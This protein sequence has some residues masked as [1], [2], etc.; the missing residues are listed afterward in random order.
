MGNKNRSKYSLL[1]GVFS[2]IIMIVIGLIIPRMY[3]INYGQ[4]VHGILTTVQQLFC[5]IALIEA[6]IGVSALQ[7]LYK[8]L[9]INDKN[10]INGILSATNIYYKKAGKLYFIILIIVSLLFPIIVKSSVPYYVILLVIFFSGIANAFSFYYYSKYLIL[11]R[12]EGK[13]YLISMIN[14]VVFILNNLAKILL[15]SLQVDIYLVMMI[16]SFITISQMLYINYYVKKNYEWIDLTVPPNNSAF[17]ESK[18]V[19]IHQI[20]SLVLNNTDVFVISIF[21]DIKLVSIYGIYKLFMVNITTLIFQIKNSI[22]F[23]LGQTFSGDIN[24]YKK[25]IDIYNTYYTAIVFSIFSCVSVVFLPFLTIYTN[26]MNGNYVDRHLMMLFIVIELILATRDSM[27][28][29]IDFAQHFKKT[30]WRSL[31]ESFI[32][33]TVSLVLVSQYGLYGVLYGTI[34]ALTL[35]TFDILIYSN[36]RILNRSCFFSFKILI[37]NFFVFICLYFIFNKIA[38]NIDSLLEIMFFGFVILCFNLITYFSINTLL[39]IKQ[40]KY[41]IKEMFYRK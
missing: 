14:L 4:D 13:N 32:N 24:K 1:F 23:Y 18:H 16:C 31:V 34:I 5:Y 7:S 35:R 10:G 27:L 37:T 20:S 33:L 3:V 41:L 39:N 11:M 40:S 36:K 2:Q 25:L 29:T 17:K 9:S 38:L 15:L 12:A 26:G 30:L 28:I 19:L 6:G 21:C 22:T 8:Y